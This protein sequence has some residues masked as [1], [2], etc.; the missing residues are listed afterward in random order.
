MHWIA[1]FRFDNS[2]KEWLKMN[3]IALERYL[4]DFIIRLA[5]LMC[6][7][8]LFVEIKTEL[9]CVRIKL[10]PAIFYGTGWMHSYHVFGKNSLEVCF[11]PFRNS[12]CYA[13][14]ILHKKKPC[15]NIQWAK[16]WDWKKNLFWIEDQFPM[17]AASYF[18]LHCI[19][20]VYT[21]MGII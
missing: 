14:Y 20:I 1:C 4:S 19:S 12:A 16:H 8:M 3:C 2:L 11:A 7:I 17:Q 21:R 5:L 10:K 13:G 9:L 6:S 18:L 15:W